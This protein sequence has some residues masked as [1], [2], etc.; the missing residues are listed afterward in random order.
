MLFELSGYLF[1]GGFLDWV[2]GVVWKF[3]ACLASEGP[4]GPRTPFALLF[5]GFAEA[6]GVVL[7]V[8][9]GVAEEGLLW[10]VFEDVDE[11]CVGEWPFFEAVFGAV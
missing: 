4:A 7:E 9:A 10:R 11:R 5:S 2:S 6:V 8:D 1:S 3:G